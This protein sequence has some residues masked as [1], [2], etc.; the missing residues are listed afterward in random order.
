MKYYYIIFA[1]V[2][3]IA[4]SAYSN[5][6]YVSV[7]EPYNATILNNGSIFLG[8]VGP[9]EPFYITILSSTKNS[10]GAVF[11]YGWNRLVAYGLPPG[12]VA[13]NS[14]LNNPKLSAEITA[15]PY[16]MNGTYKFYLKAIDNYLKLGNLTFVAFVNVTPNVFNMKVYPE[17]ISVG[18]GQPAT[19]YVGINNTG[20]SDSPF[21]I[22]TYGIPAWNLS[23]TVIAPHSTSKSFSYRIYAYD[24][25]MYKVHLLVNSSVSPLVNKEANITLLVQATVPNDYEA[26]GNGALAFPNV[27]APTYA[28][29]YLIDKLSKYV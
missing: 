11:D 13:V 8:K 5:T 20:V 17:N 25:G 12:W 15:A 18:P 27:Y 19:I 22:N 14:S 2:L 26:I 21:I 1:F 28:V 10:S 23:E 29:M 6:T 9:G 4:I 24:P 3:A 7:V 16:A